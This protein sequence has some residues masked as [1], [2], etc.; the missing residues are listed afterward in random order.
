MSTRR[1]TFQLPG[2]DCTT[3][4][5][6]KNALEH[7]EKNVKMWSDKLIKKEEMF[8]ELENKLNEF[9]NSLK[10]PSTDFKPFNSE[11]VNNNV[12]SENSETKSEETYC[13]EEDSEVESSESNDVLEMEAEDL[14]EAKFVCQLWNNNPLYISKCSVDHET[15]II[16]Q[17]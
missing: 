4:G 7:T 11:E 12:Q 17:K 9:V 8:Q 1:Q 15:L 10:I 16:A 2:S 3:Y 5:R 14:I 13:S 6:T